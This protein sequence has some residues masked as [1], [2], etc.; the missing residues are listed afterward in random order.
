M[1]PKDEARIT[2]LMNYIQQYQ[3]ENGKAP[4]Y[5]QIQKDL[6]YQYLNSVTRDVASLKER[7]L[8]VMDETG[9]WKSIYIPDNLRKGKTIKASLLGTCACGEPMTAVE[10]IVYTC[11]LPVEIFGESPRFLLTAKG[12]S[13]IGCGI[14]NGDIMVVLA[15]ETADPGQIVIARVHEGEDATAKILAKDEN[16]YYLRP[17]NDEL[18]EDGTRKYNDIHLDGDWSILGVVTHVIH[19]A[20]LEQPV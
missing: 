13:M 12:R 10:D 18:N 20:R 8:I 4:T 17:A 15:Q 1:R 2:R 7:G 11:A 5:R 19:Q 16:G 3:L 9:P 14:Y 6:S